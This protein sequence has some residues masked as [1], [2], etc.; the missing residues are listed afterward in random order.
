LKSQFA[1]WDTLAELETTEMKDL[2]SS[3][4][5]YDDEIVT[6]QDEID[7]KKIIK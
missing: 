7:P 2:F 6:I 1:E 3:I 4:S 5:K